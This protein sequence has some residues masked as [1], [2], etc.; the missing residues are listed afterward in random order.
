MIR[1]LI[2]SANWMQ[3]SNLHCLLAGISLPLVT[4][5]NRRTF[6]M[7]SAALATQ[8]RPSALASPNDTIRVACIGVRNQGRTHIQRFSKTQDAWTKPPAPGSERRGV[9]VAAICDI[10]ESVLAE[11]LKDFE[12]MGSKRPTTYSDPR[13]LLE[14]KSID[15]IAITTPNHWH[16][17]LAIWACQAGK[18][19]YVE[20]PCSH[21]VFEARQIVA[22]ARKY[23]RIVQQ[24]TQARSSAG[25]QEAAQKLREGIIGDVYMARGICFRWRS[26]IGRAKEEP[27]PAGVNYDLWT[28][29]AGV[30]PFTRNR[31]HYNWHWQ[32]EY[33]N[34]EIGN[35]AIHELDVC[36]WLLGVKY[37][38]KVTSAGGHYLFDDDQ[39]TPNHQLSTFEFNE[40]GKKKSI[41]FEIR[42]WYTNHETK[43]GSQLPRHAVGTMFYGSKGYMACGPDG[44]ET[45]LGPEQQP[46]PRARRSGDHYDNFLNA[47]RSR[48]PSDLTAEIETGAESTV[49]IHLANAAYRTGRTL[50]FDSK[51]LTCTGDPE[52]NKLLTR[53]Y[54][55]P[56]IV[57][58]KV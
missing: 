54:R 58:E 44:Y 47:V 11:R 15:A 32:W 10:D 7:N 31:F 40:G 20:K 22:A 49:L 30:R 16:T 41:V 53:N 12:A 13:R 34:G 9:Q 37:P 14:D 39:E 56:F 55:P 1:P 28:G 35:Q 43:I 45:F 18:D 25:L 8:V 23:N 46:G 17:L 2:R 51:N 5:M 19:V 29:P 26:E 27:V 48:K 24:G 6:F 33:G 50:N 57:P 52:A 3:G 21:N 4:S 42:P 38:T 36:R